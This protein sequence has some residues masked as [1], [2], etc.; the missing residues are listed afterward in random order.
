MAVGTS[1]VDQ[2]F[3]RAYAMFSTHSERKKVLTSLESMD[4]TI[5]GAQL[6]L[7]EVHFPADITETIF[8][9]NIDP[10]NTTKEEMVAAF[11]KYGLI[12]DVLICALK[13]L[14]FLLRSLTTLSAQARTRQ[15]YFAHIV[16]DSLQAAQLAIHSA[17][18]DPIRLHD[19]TLVVSP[20]RDPPR[21]VL[22]ISG[23]L[24][25]VDDV[26][27]LFKESEDHIEDI[28]LG[29]SQT[30]YARLHDS[31][32]FQSLAK[33]ETER[34]RCGSGSLQLGKLSKPERM[35]SSLI[36]RLL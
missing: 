31:R 30:T 3:G 12:Q 21:R 25:G 18:I 2:F 1:A 13:Q 33:A 17:I 5:H 11:S 15:T 4:L 28:R 8:V 14:R 6:A 10:E 29:A 26:R 7:S 36:L 23:F 19:K 27:S 35:R 9:L 16:F 34:R 24:G 22:C 20:A 32:P